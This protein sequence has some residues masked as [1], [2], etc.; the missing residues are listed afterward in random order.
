MTNFNL[1]EMYNLNAAL[2]TTESVGEWDGQEE[3][4]AE[5]VNRIYTA[6]YK[7]APNDTDTD[8]LAEIMHRV[9]DEWGSEEKLLTLTDEDV[10]KYV[11][12]VF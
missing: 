7:A 2:A 5:N 9:W 11:S 8:T 3:L 1:K 12:K 4:A 6:I 10:E